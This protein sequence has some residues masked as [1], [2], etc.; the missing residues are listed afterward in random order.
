MASQLA[1]LRTEVEQISTSCSKSA[2]MLENFT[3]QFQTQIESIT[4]TVGGS[5]QRKDQE[6]I[7]SLNAAITAIKNASESL[8]EAGKTASDY[9]NQM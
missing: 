2:S 7:S 9:A 6:M 5:A 3:R 8:T 4:R 1:K